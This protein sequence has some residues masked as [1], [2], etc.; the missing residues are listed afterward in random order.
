MN[1]ANVLEGKRKEFS[2]G[3][4]FAHMPTVTN[5]ATPAVRTVTEITLPRFR[6][7]APESG[8]GW[9]ASWQSSI[10]QCPKFGSGE[11]LPNARRVRQP[12]SR[13]GVVRRDIVTGGR[14]PAP[15]A[16]Q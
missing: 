3:P 1:P 13:T 6:A 12:R 14:R 16:P 15:A 4:R 2:A 9:H 11:E 7:V 5:D 10:D 8:L